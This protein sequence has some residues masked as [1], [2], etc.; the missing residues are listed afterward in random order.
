MVAFSTLPNIACPLLLGLLSLLPF[1]ILSVCPHSIPDKNQLNHA[2][3]RP[4]LYALLCGGLYSE[5]T[6][7]F[8]IIVLHAVSFWENVMNFPAA[9]F[10][11]AIDRCLNKPCHNISWPLYNR[12]CWISE[13]HQVDKFGTS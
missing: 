4:E 3:K 1:F 5:V 13:P 6:S 8:N 12:S 11:V 10:C 9:A 2:V 7:V